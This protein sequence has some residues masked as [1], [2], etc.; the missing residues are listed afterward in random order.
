MNTLLDGLRGSRRRL[1]GV[2]LRSALVAAALPAAGCVPVEPGFGCASNAQCITG[3]GQQG[4]CET[5]GY[6]GFPDAACEG[7]GRRHGAAAPAELASQ[8]VAAP[9]EA[10]CVAQISAGGRHTCAVK[11]DGSVWCWGDNTLGQL[12]DGTVEVRTAPV[13]VEALAGTQIVQISGGIDH[14]CAL[15]AGGDV[16]CWGDNAMGQLGVVDAGGKKLPG[17]GTP[18]K[19]TGLPA[20]KAFSAGGKHTCAV[21]QAG[22]VWCFGENSASQLGDGTQAERATPVQVAGLEQVVSVQNGDE[23]T[24]ALGQSGGVWCWGKNNAKQIGVESAGGMAVEPV[25]VDALTSVVQ[26]GVGDEHTCVLR[27]GNTVWCWGYN[28]NGCVGN[29]SGTDQSVPIKVFTAEHLALSGS[30]FHSCAITDA[31]GGQVWCWG[32]NETGQIGDGGEEGDAS[33]PVKVKLVS[34]IDV[35]VG[36]GHS[37]A[38]TAD[39]ELWCWGDDTHHELAGG[40]DQER[41]NVPVR[42]PICP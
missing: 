31:G 7:T 38:L 21:D 26:L 25:A 13:K 16:H 39:G 15:T 2:L 18:R 29:G 8:C 33:V 11:K 42:V 41:S 10:G 40:S 24:C 9:A 23:H 6:C 32:S 20:V 27:K 14:T 37:C 5:T 12:G 1:R 4:I 22:S 17:G 35:V 19:V 30:S 28:G 3:E 36:G 34:A